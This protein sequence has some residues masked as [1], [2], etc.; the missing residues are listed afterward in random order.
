MTE[1]QYYSKYS[2]FGTLDIQSP[3]VP[4][5]LQSVFPQMGDV[6]GKEGVEEGIQGLA[7]P[8]PLSESEIAALEA[9]KAAGEIAGYTYT[10]PQK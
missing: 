7:L 4:T 3:A 6:W 2:R 8:Q 1:E 10:P 9:A 5:S